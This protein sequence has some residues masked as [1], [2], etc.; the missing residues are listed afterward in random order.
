MSIRRQ[1]R[2]HT[3]HLHFHPANR[4]GTGQ[5]AK[6]DHSHAIRPTYTPFPRPFREREQRGALRRDKKSTFVALL[7][8]LSYISIGSQEHSSGFKSSDSRGDRDGG[9]ATFGCWVRAPPP[10]R[11]AMEYN[12][13]MITHAVNHI[14]RAGECVTVLWRDGLR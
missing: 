2:A 13:Q 11:L 14:Q 5:S 6:H 4:K 8:H 3:E 10:P 9:T 12:V 7:E 1:S